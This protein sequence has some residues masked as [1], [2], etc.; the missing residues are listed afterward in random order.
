VR[1]AYR[2]R[3]GSDGTVEIEMYGSELRL[4]NP[5]PAPLPVRV[6]RLETSFDSVA[7]VEAGHDRTIPFTTRDGRLV[8]T[9]RV[10][11]GAS[12]L[13]RIRY[14]AQAP[15][16]LRPA[17]P[18]TIKVAA[19]RILSEFRDEWVQPLRFRGRPS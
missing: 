3:Q 6:E 7:A 12:H 8:F 10:P 11:P 16:R 19:R 1:R 4:D 2:R 17:V 5:G 9:D 18:Y 13:Y 15:P 14:R